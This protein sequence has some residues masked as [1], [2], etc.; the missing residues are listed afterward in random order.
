MPYFTEIEKNGY[1]FK[2]TNIKPGMI[3]FDLEDP[4]TA[5]DL[6]NEKLLPLVTY[7]S[8][9]LEG[10]AIYKEMCDEEHAR[11]KKELLLERKSAEEEKKK[12]SLPETADIGWIYLLKTERDEYK[13]GLTR[14]HPTNRLAA[15]KPQMPYG[16]ELIGSIKSKKVSEDEVF[17][18]TLYRSKRIKGEWFA[19]DEIDV[20]NILNIPWVSS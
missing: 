2:A 5:K 14:D 10:D 3:F 20:E 1:K 18:H 19:L 12:K 11:D 6:E 15:I 8:L 13:I 7:R 16:V 17:L 4:K 9:V